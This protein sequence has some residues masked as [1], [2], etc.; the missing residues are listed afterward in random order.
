[1]GPIGALKEILF[2]IDDEHLLGNEALW[3]IIIFVND[4]NCSCR[5]EGLE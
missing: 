1:M 2:V 4:V 5:T 3:R